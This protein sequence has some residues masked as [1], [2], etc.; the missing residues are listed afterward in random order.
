MTKKRGKIYMTTVF[1]YKNES[2]VDS[3]TW[4]WYN[5]LYRATTAIE[6]NMGDMFEC[7][8]ELRIS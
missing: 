6:T 7:T 5:D 2:T 4:A 1:L 3:R 8:Y